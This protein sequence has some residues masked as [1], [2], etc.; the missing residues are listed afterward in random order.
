MKLISICVK[1]NDLIYNDWRKGCC[2]VHFSRQWN[3]NAVVCQLL[4]EMA[5]M[6]MIQDLMNFLQ[7][8]LLQ[9]SSMASRH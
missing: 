2:Q 3:G 8:K 1:S 9:N 6:V 4:N 5:C 7:S